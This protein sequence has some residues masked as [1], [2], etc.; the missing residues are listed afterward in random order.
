MNG[1]I[2]VLIVDREAFFRRG[3]VACLDAN[4]RLQVVGNVGTAAEG[5]QQADDLTP[6]V[7]LVGT[8]L[9]DA[10]GLE[11]ATEMR[12]R[13]PA[14]ASVVVTD[15]ENDEEFFAAIRAG[16]SVYVGKD[17][18]EDELIALIERAATGEYVI[19]EQFSEQTVCGR[20]GAGAVPQHDGER[21]GAEERVCS[22]DRSG[23]PDSA[24]GQ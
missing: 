9:T 16:A 23:A 13:F 2:E 11:A 10:P 5:Y 15:E 17:V 7:A 19:N 1:E 3:L 4:P 6:D 18:P 24:E 14:M 20:P 12:R 22:T 8:T 21:D